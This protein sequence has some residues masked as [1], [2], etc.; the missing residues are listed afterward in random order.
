M[1]G[2]RSSARPQDLKRYA[3]VGTQIN[4]AFTFEAS[5]LAQKLAQFEATCTEYHVDVGYLPDHWRRYTANAQEVDDWVRSVGRQFEEADRPGGLRGFLAS[6]GRKI[7]SGAGRLRGQAGRTLSRLRQEIGDAGRAVRGVFERAVSRAADLVARGRRALSEAGREVRRRIEQA[8]SFGPTLLSQVRPAAGGLKAKAER[9]LGRLAQRLRPQLQS[10]V[11]TLG[12]VPGAGLVAGAVVELLNTATGFGNAI[13]HPT[14]TAR[15]WGYAIRYPAELWDGFKQP[16]VEDWNNGHRDRAIG[17]GLTLLRLLGS[18]AFGVALTGNLTKA[19]SEAVNSKRAERLTKLLELGR[20]PVYSHLLEERWP[21][22]TLDDHVA[23]QSLRDPVVRHKRLMFDEYSVRVHLP[24]DVDP[25]AYLAGMARDMDR[26]L[27]GPV[28]LRAN[29][30]RLRGG[31]LAVGQVIDIDLTNRVTLINRKLDLNPWNA[32]VVITEY[33]PNS[34]FVVQTI[35]RDGREHPLHGVRQWGYERLRDG[36]VRFYTTAVSVEDVW[37]AER[38][39]TWGESDMWRS[40]LDS[41]AGKVRAEG[42]SVV[43]GTRTVRQVRMPSMDTLE[44]EGLLPS[45]N[46]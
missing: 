19:A 30:K 14:R 2:S 38:T 46:S 35:E 4:H 45:K 29:F 16:Y 18:P 33:D 24:P 43:P 31:E 12:E 3:Q 40:W 20:L 21:R 13:V 39:G 34:H 9:M 17:R 25:S 42:G 1:S 32:P 37:I 22:L 15:E 11:R 23:I 36:S 6:A 28:A 27:G 44:R 26:F 41:V 7:T 5:H 8:L 10:A